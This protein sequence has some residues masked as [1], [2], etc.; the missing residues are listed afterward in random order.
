[1]V[2]LATRSADVDLGARLALAS[3]VVRNED[4]SGT[5]LDSFKATACTFVAT[6]FSKMWIGDAQFGVGPTQTLYRGCTFDGSTIYAIDAGNAR[7]ESCR[8]LG[9]TLI[10]WVTRGVEMVDC[11]F[12][13][14][15]SQAWF[16]GELDAADAAYYGRTA[17]E[18]SG[19]DFRGTSLVSVRFDGIALDRQLLPQS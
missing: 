15:I 10:D 17:N 5:R 8:F 4:F 7:F 1:M 12:T 6:D 9:V 16:S 18:F 13:G 14:A 11:E 2:Q 3:Q 19:N